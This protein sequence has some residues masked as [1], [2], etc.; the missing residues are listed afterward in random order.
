MQPAGRNDLLLAARNRLAAL[1]VFFQIGEQ[2]VMLRQQLV[3]TAKLCGGRILGGEQAFRR[4]TSITL[5]PRQ[6]IYHCNAHLHR[7]LA[8]SIG[9]GSSSPCGKVAPRTALPGRLAGGA[10]NS[11]RAENPPF[12]A[13]SNDRA[14]P[15]VR[16]TIRRGGP[17][18]RRIIF[19]TEV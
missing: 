15:I 9:G 2:I 5:R 13:R 1:E 19:A 11:L 12:I 8:W 17:R 7:D 3:A 14:R 18:F 16:L 6:M 4:S 10:G